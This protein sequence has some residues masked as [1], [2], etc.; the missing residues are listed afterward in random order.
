MDKQIFKKN[1]RMMK[2]ILGCL[3]LS[4]LILPASGKIRLPRLVSNGMI[5]Q[6]DIPVNVWGWAAPGEHITLSFDHQTYETNTDSQGR[7]ALVLQPHPA[8]GPWQMEFSASNRIVLSDILFGDVWLCSGQSNMELPLRRT[9]VLYGDEIAASENSEIRQFLVPVQWNYASPQD[10]IQGGQWEAANPE[11]V[12]K[13]STVGYFFA[14]DLQARYKVPQGI[15][16]CAAGGSCAE[17]WMSEN[18]L[19]EFPAQYEVAR[20]LAD[21]VYLKNL[22]DSERRAM[23]DWFGYLGQNDL[24]HQTIAWFSPEL[25]DSSWDSFELPNTFQA[26][27]LDFKFGAI[28]LRKTIE[29]PETCQGEEALLELGRIVD[30]DSVF[31]NGTFIGNITYQYPPRRYPI[32]AGIL[33]SGRN[34]ITVRVVSQSWGGGFIKDK[35]Y[36]LVCGQQVTDLKGIWKYRI[37]AKSGPC[38]SSTY[39]PGKPMGLY[40]AMLFPMKNYT[41]KGFVWYQGESNAERAGDYM[42]ALTALIGEWRSLWDQGNLPFLYVQLPDFME[43]VQNPSE[44]GWATLRDQQRQILSLQGTAMAVTLGLGEWNDIHPLRKKEVGQRLALAAQQLVFGDTQVVASGPVYQSMKREGNSL[45][46]SFSE[47]GSG[48]VSCDDQALHHFAIAGPDGSFIWAEAQIRGNQVVVSSDKISNP[49]RVRYAWADNP[50][51]ANLCNREGLPA[52]PFTTDF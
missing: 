51:G 15:I 9:A 25:D 6:R 35:P 49:T 3:F 37:G 21:S 13:F 40:N 5:L 19:K 30:S 11:S 39:F 24:G 31:V 2:R 34:T 10:D 43:P 4:V 47:C 36:Q 50:K 32:P 1:N 12:L 44:G 42:R 26:A 23:S 28:W 41:L 22:L 52:S 33:K 29:L 48:L 27:G 14:R 46:L 7:W 18:T 38:P 45:V 16:L 17:G 20:Q 8:G